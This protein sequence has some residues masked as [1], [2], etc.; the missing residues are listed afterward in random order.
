MMMM[1]I[2]GRRR[3]VF[4]FK[5]QQLKEEVFTHLSLLSEMYPMSLLSEM[6]LNCFN[7]FCLPE[8]SQPE[9]RSTLIGK[10]DSKISEP[11]TLLGLQE[12]E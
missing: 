2:R 12:Y 3:G 9:K 11:D 10:R 6:K 1:M 7:L 5:N 8:V 4:Y